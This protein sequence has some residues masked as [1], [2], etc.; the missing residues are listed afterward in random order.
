MG[1]FDNLFNHI[2]SYYDAP[3][4]HPLAM[5]ARVNAGLASMTSPARIE[6][7]SDYW[8]IDLP[9]PGIDPAHIR[10][11][12]ANQVIT[13]VSDPAATEFGGPRVDQTL[14]VPAFLDLDRLTARYRY[15]VLELTVPIQE[16][17]KRR[18]VEI[19]GLTSSPQRQ[20]TVG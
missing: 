17:S 1:S 19:E 8:R 2:N 18:H 6:R 3:F 12:V 16:S 13:L 5:I 7:T 15:G 14:R 10:L 9:V 11:S 20:L 4:Y